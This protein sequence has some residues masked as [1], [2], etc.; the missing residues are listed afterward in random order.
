MKFQKFVDNIEWNSKNL[1]KIIS[2]D[3]KANI[4]QQEIKD[5][6]TVTHTFFGPVF[7]IMILVGIFKP[8]LIQAVVHIGDYFWVEQIRRSKN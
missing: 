1:G 7:F 3:L 8:A 4:K 5:L 2:A 6:V